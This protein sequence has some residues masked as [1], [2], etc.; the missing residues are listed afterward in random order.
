MGSLTAG[1]PPEIAS[2]LEAKR[3]VPEDV[4]DYFSDGADLI[5]GLANGEPV[6]VVDALEAGAGRLSEVT[7]HQ[8]FPLRTRRYMHG[9]FDSLKH[10]CVALVWWIPTRTERIMVS[11]LWEAEEGLLWTR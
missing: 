7:I 6:T 9:D 8:M 2:M 1:K 3:G 4:F 10:W 11:C 5:T